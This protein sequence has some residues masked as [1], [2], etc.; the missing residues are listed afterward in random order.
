MKKLQ[1]LP[2]WVMLKC[3]KRFLPVK[4]PWKK[5]ITLQDWYEKRTTLSCDLDQIM[6]CNVVIFIGLAIYLFKR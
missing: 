2:G 6:W 1:A 4:H 3:M 5:Q